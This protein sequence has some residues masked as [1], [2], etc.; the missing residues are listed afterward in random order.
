MNVQTIEMEQ[1][2]AQRLVDL[3]RE[4]IKTANATNP[5]LATETDRALLRCYKHLAAG[6]RLID[7]VS[8]MRNENHYDDECRPR[9]AFC[10]ATATIVEWRRTGGDSSAGEFRDRPRVKGKRATHP[11]PDGTFRRWRELGHAD[12]PRTYWGTHKARVPLIPLHLRP[13]GLSNYFILFEAEW[14]PIPPKDPMLLKQ[15]HDN[16]FVVVA[17]WNL[18][19]LERAVLQ[20][21]M[22]KEQ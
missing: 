18:T 17:E 1:T 21:I 14:N 3:Y 4:E 2:E 15:L 19:D 11:F 7:V 13:S 10:R 12:R 5:G 8:V 9:L 22:R 20:G 6:R 16:V